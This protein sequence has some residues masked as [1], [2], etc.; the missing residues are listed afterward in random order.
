MNKKMDEDSFKYL[1]DTVFTKYVREILTKSNLLQF[2]NHLIDEMW[3]IYTVKNKATHESMKDKEELIDRHKV[4]A[5]IA[6]SIIKIEPI[7]I[8][9]T[10]GEKKTYFDFLPNEFL[11]I[12]SALGTLKFFGLYEAKITNNMTMYKFISQKGFDFPICKEKT[13][14]DHIARALY[15]SKNTSSFDVFTYALV[16]FLI[17]EYTFNKH[18]ITRNFPVI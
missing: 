7:K 10:K 3:R 13:F 1:W 2:R 17:E 9:G 12:K 14:L 18:N 5:L 11:A 16:F 4:A 6:Y 8:I 15:N